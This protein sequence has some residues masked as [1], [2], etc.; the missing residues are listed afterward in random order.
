L[1]QLAEAYTT[2]AE[3]AEE[4]AKSSQ[5]DHHQA[6]WLATRKQKASGTYATAGGFQL[7]LPAG[8]RSRGLFGWLP[9]I[10][11][12]ARRLPVSLGIADRVIQLRREEEPKDRDEGLH[13]LVEKGMPGQGI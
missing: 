6:A 1:V 12:L 3:Q 11:G 8:L 2:L 4:K 13:A 5:T 7:P 10:W 9:R